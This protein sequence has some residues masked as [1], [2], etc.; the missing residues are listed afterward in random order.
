MPFLV[1]LL[2]SVFYGSADFFGGYASRRG[3]VTIVT[4]LTQIL[5]MSVLLVAAV[6]IPGAPTRA[7]VMWAVSAGVSGGVGVLLLYLALSLGSVSAVAPLISLIAVAVP[8]GVGLLLGERPGLLPLSGIAL[9]LLAIVAISGGGAHHETGVSTRVT[10]RAL[11][12]AVASGVLVGGFLVAIGRIGPGG[13]VWPLVIS[14]GTGAVIVSVVALVRR[15]KW[16]I[17]PGSLGVLLLCGALDSGANLL[18]LWAVQRAPLSLTATLVSLAPA[19]T[20]VLAQIV[21]RERLTAQQKAGIALAL[22]AIVLISQ[23]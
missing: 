9:G 11:A 2:A 12:V 16:R 13:G 17:A 8:V 20:V 23:R 14:R 18:Y 6:L 3:S 19:S 1:A 21:F 10:G 7:D 4:A 15:A 5:G 22:V